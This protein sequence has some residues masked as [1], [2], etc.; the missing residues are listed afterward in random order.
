MTVVVLG[1]FCHTTAPRDAGWKNLFVNYPLNVWAIHKSTRHMSTSPLRAF[2]ESIATRADL[3]AAT[4]AR[5]DIA[6]G[7]LRTVL[8]PLSVVDR[9]QTITPRR[10]GTTTFMF[11]TAY[12]QN[13]RGSHIVASFPSWVAACFQ[14]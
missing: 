10:T 11:G 6:Q 14:D 13:G 8:K 9:R 12:S 7:N 3:K 2:K 1:P 5:P 4:L